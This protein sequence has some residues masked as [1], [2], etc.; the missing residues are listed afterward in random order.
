[1]TATGTTKAR[2]LW[3]V[4]IDDSVIDASVEANIMVVAGTEGEVIALEISSGR[5]IAQTFCEGGLLSCTLNPSA[6]HVAL[7]GPSGSW[8]WH[9]QSNTKRELLVDGWCAAAEWASDQ[10]LA[11]GWGKQVVVFDGEGDR[12]WS[13][14]DFPSTITALSWLGGWKRLAIAAYGGVHIVEPRLRGSA[15]QMKFTGSLLDLVSSPDGR[16]IVSGNQD[17]TLQVFRSDNKTR[18]EME[19]FPSK[20]DSVRFDSS[21]KY[22][23]NN[24]APELAVWDFSGSGPRGRMPVLCVSSQNE[25]SDDISCF[26]WHPNKPVVVLAWAS[27]LVQ[28]YQVTKGLPGKP[29]KPERTWA[30]ESSQVRAIRWM[31]MS[32]ALVIAKEDGQI[33]AFEFSHGS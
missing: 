19:G 26:A 15:R 30:E 5:I 23:D 21:G 22:L 10:R 31:P 24:G 1:M 28:T 17:A 8:L 13:S 14:L 20:I 32:D 25:T 29:L 2:Q 11:I 27:G 16:W 6:T 12:I 9:V 33:N 7:T 18:L 3:T 4:G